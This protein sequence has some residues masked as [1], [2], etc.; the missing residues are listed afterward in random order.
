MR[1]LTPCAWPGTT[2]TATPYPR[3]S[4]HY[5]KKLVKVWERGGPMPRSFPRSGHVWRFPNYLHHVTLLHQC[6]CLFVGKTSPSMLP[7]VLRIAW[8]PV[9]NVRSMWPSLCRRWA[10]PGQQYPAE[11][12]SSPSRELTQDQDVDVKSILPRALT[13]LSSPDAGRGQTSLAFRCTTNPTS[14]S[15]RVTGATGCTPC[16]SMLQALPPAS[17]T[18]SLEDVSVHPNGLGARGIGQDSDLGRRKYF[19]AEDEHPGS[20]FSCC[21]N[22]N[23]SPIYFPSPHCFLCVAILFYS[24]LPPFRE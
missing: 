1:N 6:G 8:D 19:A 21:C 20:G 16:A 13:V 14:P 9:A 15:G 11:V 4:Q 17:V 2:D 10:H 23:P 3:S 7:T 5:L 12:K 22:G 24:Q 18:P